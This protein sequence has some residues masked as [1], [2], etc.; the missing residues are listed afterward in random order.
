MKHHPS[1]AD[2]GPH[3]DPAKEQIWRERLNRFS[4]SGQSVR[5]F[6]ATHGLRETAFCF[7]RS[8]IRRRDGKAPQRRQLAT[9]RAPRP[10]A[11][12][13]VVV[14]PPQ[15][16][17]QEGLRLRLGGERELLLPASMALEQVARLIRAIEV[18][19]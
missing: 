18:A 7:W 1:H 4:A 5:E 6:C 14:R 19:A 12:A 17:V 10:L 3:R 13:R 9:R 2:K 16:A 11:F 8:E 15:P